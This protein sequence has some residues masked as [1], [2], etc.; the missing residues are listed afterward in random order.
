M[1]AKPKDQDALAAFADELKAWRAARGWTQGQLAAQTNYSE[2]MIAQVETARKPATMQ[3]GTVLDRV[4]GT[5]GFTEATAD[6]PGTPGTFM[7]L[8]ARI[9]KLSFPV[10]F[11]PFTDAEEEATT[12]LIFE[13]ALFPGLFQTESYARAVLETYPHV[14]NEQVAARL[15]ARLSRQ[16]IV[17]GSKAPRLWVLLYEPVLHH[18]VDSLETMRDQLLR[19][20]EASRLPNVTVQIL[21]AAIHVAMQGSFH[22]AVVDGVSTATFIADATDGRTT[23]DPTTM[24]GLSEFFR[25]LQAEA[26]TPKA[27][28]ELTE[29]VASEL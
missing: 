21:P 2:Q 27:S 14:T 10:A 29:R 23:Q 8:A 13:H 17:A 9:R 19:M 6:K 20:V 3:M 25:Y 24:N 11:R 18:L 4:F 1:P 5:P 7:R 16:A 22:I 26:M 15:A 12:L 28:R